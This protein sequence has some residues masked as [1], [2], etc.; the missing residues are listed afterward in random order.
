MKVVSALI[1]VAKNVS[2][3]SDNTQV[4]ANF[5]LLVMMRIFEMGL[6]HVS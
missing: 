1:D 3:E 4:N 6:L 5:L 2:I